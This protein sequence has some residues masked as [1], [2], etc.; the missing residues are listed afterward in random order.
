[1]ELLKITCFWISTCSLLSPFTV[2]LKK[3]LLWGSF[4]TTT[5]LPALLTAW[6]IAAS[7][8]IKIVKKKARKDGNN[9]VDIHKFFAAKEQVMLNKAIHSKRNNNPTE[10]SDSESQIFLCNLYCNSF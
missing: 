1:M 7:S 9:G 8:L 3:K 2:S 4:L 6:R 10:I 5:Q